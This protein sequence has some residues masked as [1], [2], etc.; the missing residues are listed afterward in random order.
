MRTSYYDRAYFANVVTKRFPF[1]SPPIES[2]PVMKHSNPSCDVT[3]KASS[4]LTMKYLVD[5]NH[6][7]SCNLQYSI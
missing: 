7:P 3:F 4:V 6:K 1:F 2:G 5:L